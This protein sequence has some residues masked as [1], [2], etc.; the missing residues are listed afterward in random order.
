MGIKKFWGFVAALPLLGA[1]T[2]RA[3]PAAAPALT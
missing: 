2:A 3:Q 1:V